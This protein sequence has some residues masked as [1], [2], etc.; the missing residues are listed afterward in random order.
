M[1]D[2]AKIRKSLMHN[3]KLMDAKMRKVPYSGKY[4]RALKLADLP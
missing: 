1:H 2:A 3:D 4:W